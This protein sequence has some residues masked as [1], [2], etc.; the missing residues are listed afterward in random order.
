MGMVLGDAISAET[1]NRI[2]AMLRL[3]KRKIKDCR[4]NPEQIRGTI[5][6][7]RSLTKNK[8]ISEELEKDSNIFDIRDG[9]KRLMEVV[10]HDPKYL[11]YDTA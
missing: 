7:L 8:S 6:L 11:R 1:R 9:T 5:E 3:I 10:N 4:N 2:I